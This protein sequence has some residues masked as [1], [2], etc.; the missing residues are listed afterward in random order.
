MRAPLIIASTD[1]IEVHYRKGTSSFLWI[2][3]APLNVYAD[4]VTYWGQ[5]V[6]DMADFNTLA[7]MPKGPNWY[8]RDDML[9]VMPHIEEILADHVDRVT[10][11]ASMGGY[12]VLKYSSLL[13][14][15]CALSFSPQATIDPDAIDVSYNPHRVHYK[16]ELHSDMTIGIGDVVP[17]A[18]AIFDSFD[19]I[20]AGNVRKIHEVAPHMTTVSVP[21]FGHEVMRV[22]AG[23]A[24]TKLVID[25]A[26]TGDLAG[27]TKLGSFRRTMPTRA[28][29]VLQ[30]Y[31][32]KS[33]YRAAEMFKA[34]A[35][36]L[37]AREAVSFYNVLKTELLK[38]G[39]ADAAE[40]AS[41]EVTRLMVTPN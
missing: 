17:N 9:G 25:K 7:F 21:M 19:Y 31:C 20:D 33:P 12:A 5:R 34:Y 35:D 13:N 27:L 29:V 37:S 1:N 14:A 6:A 15:T 39:D 16:P 24:T 28:R 40:E 23:T 10:F 38:I 18:I 26:R 22:F 2:P 8:P 36:R 41:R 3:F 4:G 30:R 11:G 32:Q